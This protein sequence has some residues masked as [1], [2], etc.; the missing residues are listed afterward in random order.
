[1]PHEVPFGWLPSAEH[2]AL[3]LVQTMAIFAHDPVVEQSVPVAQA[4]HAPALHTPPSSHVVPFATDPVFVHSSAPPSQVVCPVRH[5]PGV[6][7]E[8]P[9]HAI[10][11]LLPL[12]AP[13]WQAVN[14]PPT[15]RKESSWS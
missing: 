15:F 8:P 13:S 4:E 2:T 3:P 10:A 9:V 14:P 12:S 5:A 11:S 6:H 1:V 7:A